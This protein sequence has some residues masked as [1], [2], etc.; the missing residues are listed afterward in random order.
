MTGLKLVSVNIEFTKHL[1]RVKSFLKREDPDIVCMQE[2]QE[3]TI[4]EI[5]LALG[6][7]HHVFAPMQRQKYEG[8]MSVVGVGI[9][10]RSR[11]EN[12]TVRYYTEERELPTLD[13]SDP[14]SYINKLSPV[15][16]CDV[17]VNDQIFKIATIH[18]TWSPGGKATDLQ[19][20]H[21]KRLLEVLSTEGDFVLAG[22]FNAP[23][24]REIFTLLS[25]K[26]KDNI[27]S[28]YST[29]LDPDL[30][31]AGK[32]DLM[33]DGLFTTPSYIAEGVELHNGVSDHCA[34]TA[35]IKRANS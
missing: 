23:R 34:I 35:T 4:A 14:D 19:R 33:V 9:F 2:I 21:M 1:E 24:G 29:S 7:E 30:H 32:L 11:F 20:T 16:F 18:F 31:R 12:T 22:D 10:S 17:R 26:Y 3:D 5:A 27:P 15:L 25:A 13:T 28:R 6:F 8:S